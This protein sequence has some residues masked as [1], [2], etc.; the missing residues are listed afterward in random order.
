MIYCF[1]DS[2]SDK[3]MRISDVAIS[4]PLK[5]GA[6]QRIAFHIEQQHEPDKDLPLR[7]FQGYYRM[8]DRLRVPVTSLAIL[9][10]N[11]KPVNAYITSCYGTE[12]NFKFGVYHVAS[13]DAEELK[14][15]G[16]VF[17]VVVLAA[18]RMLDAGDNPR[19]RGKYSL[20]L[21]NLTRERGCGAGKMR[22]IQKFIYR[23]LRIGDKN[24]DPKVREVW[25]MQLIPIDEAVMEIRIRDAVEEGMERGVE[26]GKFEVAR[27]MLARKM[28]V[29]D[30]IDLTG[31][32]E[33]DILTLS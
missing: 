13:A 23:I 33:I 16:R 3:G 7:M 18:K 4:I 30:I 8:S 20:E 10:G 1:I 27:K 9:T 31:L 26:K 5:T 19:E 25:K 15:D 21:L 12:L 11:I 32:D 2:D 14:R 6:D 17:A 22:D 29:S 28:A 24:I